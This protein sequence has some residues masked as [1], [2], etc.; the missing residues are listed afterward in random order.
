MTVM[1]VSVVRLIVFAPMG[2]IL[3]QDSGIDADHLG[4]L[5]I[6]GMICHLTVPSARLL[7]TVAHNIR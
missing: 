1:K 2:D 6:K 3:Q 5:N 7:G 4:Y